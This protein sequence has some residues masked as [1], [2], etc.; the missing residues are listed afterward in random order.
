[1]KVIAGRATLLAILAFAL[2]FRFDGIDWGA[3]YNYHEDV[4]GRQIEAFEMASQRSLKPTD[5]HHPTF[6]AYPL[7]AEYSTY[8]LIGRI[9]GAFFSFDDFPRP[10]STLRARS[11]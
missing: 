10:G 7:L 4:S 5:Q 6:L 9:M 1:M 11:A 8:Y 3:P 2:A